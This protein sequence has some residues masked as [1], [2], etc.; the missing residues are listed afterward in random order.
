MAQYRMN[1]SVAGL[2]Y[3]DVVEIE[4]PLLWQVEIDAGY[5]SPVGDAPEAAPADVPPEE[6]PA[7]IF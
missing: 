6:P 5:M 7:P 1:A 3:G 2:N 4:D